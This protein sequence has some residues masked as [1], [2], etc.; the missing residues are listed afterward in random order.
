MFNSLVPWHPSP[1]L[2]LVLTTLFWSGNFV[3]G[4][5]VHTVFTPFTLSFWRWAVA[6]VILLPFVGCG[7]SAALRRVFA[8][9]AKVF[10]A[11]SLADPALAQRVGRGEFQH[12]RLYRIA[13]DHGH[14]RR[15]HA[16]DDAGADRGAVVPAAAPDRHW[17]ADTRYRGVAGRSAGDC[18]AG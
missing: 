1:Y 5:A 3:L 11:P 15:D 12:L 16:I 8:A 4:R 2:L 13:I 6:L 7:H 17:L 14:Q 10:A 9:E 18:R